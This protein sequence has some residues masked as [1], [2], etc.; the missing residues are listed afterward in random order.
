[1]TRTELTEREAQILELLLEGKA[2][3]EIAASFDI[4]VRTVR[5][6]VSNIFKKKNLRTRAELMAR[7]LRRRV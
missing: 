3:K 2:D 5:F 7:E 4:S 1:V 6:H